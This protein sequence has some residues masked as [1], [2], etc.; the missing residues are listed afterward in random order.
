MSS[1]VNTLTEHQK[2]QWLDARIYAKRMW[3]DC[4]P[5]LVGIFIAAAT[6]AIIGLQMLS[7]ANGDRRLD[8]I[9]LEERTK[10]IQ[11]CADLSGALERQSC[12][13]TIDASLGR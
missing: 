11:T 8:A 4:A 1:F 5:W 10:Q 2:G 12:I 9:A 6:I 3:A 7:N 13:L